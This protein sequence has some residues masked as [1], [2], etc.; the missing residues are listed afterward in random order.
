M[1][2]VLVDRNDWRLLLDTEDISCFYF[3]NHFLETFMKKSKI[4]NASTLTCHSLK[5]ILLYCE[6]CKNKIK[7]LLDNCDKLSD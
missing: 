4:K 2:I 1:D 7:K 6:T 3:C 5:E